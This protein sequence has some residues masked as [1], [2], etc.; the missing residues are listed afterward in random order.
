M[1]VVTEKMR[2]LRFLGL[3]EY[4]IWFVGVAGN[5]ILRVVKNG[6]SQVCGPVVSIA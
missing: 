1:S 6:R 5:E 2:G 4:V 3:G